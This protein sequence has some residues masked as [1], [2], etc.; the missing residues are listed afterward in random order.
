MAIEWGSR[1]LFTSRLEPFCTPTF[2]SC[3]ALV[4]IEPQKAGGFSHF[5]LVVLQSATRSG[6]PPRRDCG[7]ALAI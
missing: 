2:L 1:R 4:R 5:A 7:L 3:F 6:V